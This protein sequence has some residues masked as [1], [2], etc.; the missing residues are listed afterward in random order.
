MLV[1][2]NNWISSISNSRVHAEQDS[3]V[4]ANINEIK[5]KGN[6]AF[7]NKEYKEALIFY[8]QAITMV[9]GCKNLTREAA[10]VL[11]NRSIVHSNLHSVTAALEDAEE[12][13]MCDQ[14]WMEGH[15]RRG[16][17]LRQKKLFRE[18]FSAFLE[19]YWKGDGT[20]SEKLNILVEAVASFSNI[21]GF[22]CYRGFENRTNCTVYLIFRY[23]ES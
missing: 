11:T 18:S 21:T 9:K 7:K 8:D 2:F 12:A 17:V 4:K 6:I 13:V 14:T 5:E 15:W 19:G 20:V 16:Q 1:D 3:H 23:F 22:V 10:I